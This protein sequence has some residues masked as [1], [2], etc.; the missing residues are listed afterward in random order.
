MNRQPAELPLVI[1]RSP[2]QGSGS[3]IVRPALLRDDAWRLAIAMLTLLLIDTLPAL[4][5]V[6]SHWQAAKS[7]G[8]TRWAGL[9]LLLAV[10][11]FAYLCYVVQLA[12]WSS[13]WVIAL[14]LLVLAMAHAVLLGLL[15]YAQPNSPL[16]NWWELNDLLSSRWSRWWALIVTSSASLLALIAGMMA[17][18][19]R[20]VVS[21]A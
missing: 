2:G 8:V 9:L 4:L 17:V 16:I 20:K 1:V 11:H 19:W 3:A 21:P 5:D 6:I 12:D 18:R 7:A 13:F 14:F 10:I 15:M